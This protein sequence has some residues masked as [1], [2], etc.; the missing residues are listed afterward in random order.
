[1]PT[2][3]TSSPER[4]HKLNEAEFWGRDTLHGLLARQ[5]TEQPQALAVANQPDKEQLTGAPLGSERQ[6]AGTAG[7]YPLDRRENLITFN[8]SGST[9]T[10]ASFVVGA[11][12]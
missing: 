9:T 2:I 6:V 10:S 7:D 5:V 1:M 12:L 4:I 3:N 8:L 11:D